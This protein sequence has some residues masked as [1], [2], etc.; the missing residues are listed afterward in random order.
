[1][2]YEWLKG[3]S[4]KQKKIFEVFDPWMQETAN[5]SEQFWSYA[6]DQF[7]PFHD[8]ENSAVSILLGGASRAGYSAV[9]EYRLRKRDRKD[10]RRW[11]DGRAD[12][13]FVAQ[14]KAFSFEFKRAWNAASSKNLAE[15]MDDATWDI[16]NVPTNESD[17]A[18]AGVIAPAYDEAEVGVY[19]AFA[20]QVDFCCR[21][22]DPQRFEVYFYLN[23]IR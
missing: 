21:L 15:V 16:K 7:Y 6:S 3:H 4:S 9:S 10:R 8:N 18:F 2:D 14:S 12:L 5:I 19:E 22:G 1:M 23:Q 11:K 13:W 17:H 20:K